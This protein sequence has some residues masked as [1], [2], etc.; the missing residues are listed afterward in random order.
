M[1]FPKYEAYKDS[2]VEWVGPV[3]GHWQVVPFF[4]QFRERKEKNIGMQESNLL[5]LSYGAIV[6]KDINTLEGLLPESFETYQIVYED[7][8]VFRLTDLQNDKRSLRSAIVGKKGIITSAYL[9]V[10][11]RG[12]NPR[13]S[14]YLFR[15]YDLTKVFYSMGGGLRQSIGY[16]DMKW[17]PV[18]IPSDGEQ[19]QIA[20]F[21][22]HETARIDALITEQQRLIELLQ[23]KRQAVI[24]HAVT[25]GLDPTVPMKD[26]GV[27]WLGEVPAHWEVTRLKHVTSMIVDCP[28][29]TPIY[30]P[31]GEYLVIRTADIDRGVLKREQMYRLDQD[32]YII[33]TRRAS[34][35]EGDIVYGRE[36]ERW[37]HAA[38]VPESGRYALGQRMMQFRAA[39]GISPSY[40]MFL[41]NSDAVYKQGDVDTVGATSPHVNVATV[42]NYSLAVPPLGEQE[43]IVDHLEAASN[44]MDMLVMTAEQA[45]HLL[46]E[47]RSALISAAVTGKIDVRGWQP[48]PDTALKSSAREAVHG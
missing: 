15:A 3:P 43:R 44:A 29:E 31:D 17:L 32:Q 9:A 19:S 26:S 8:V 24:S 47:R 10:V 16:A 37:G 40:L 25:K 41:L 23:E 2:G 22:D 14:N 34:L 5:S 35:D 39:E 48:P 28:H 46:Q 38:V 20:G 11:S 18:L 36:G 42:R 30:E 33:R 6:D 7:D 45:V 12:I 13:F 4:S 1:S 27:E 21:L